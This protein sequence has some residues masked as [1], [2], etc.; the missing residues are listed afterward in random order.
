MSAPNNLGWLGIF[1]LGL[2][3]VALGAIVIQPFTTF[4]QAIIEDLGLMAMLPGFL[5]GL[6]YIIQLTRPRIGHG[7][8]TGGRRTPWI[9]G[10]ITTL[11][12]GGIT[13]AAGILAM[14]SVLWAGIAVTVFGY[15]LIGAGSAATGT[16]LLTFLAT[17]VDAKRR[18]LAAMVVW[19]MMIVGFAVT[20]G[21]VGSVLDPFSL[22]RLFVVVSIV[23]LIAFTL[24]ALALFRLEGPDIAPVE[25]PAPPGSEPD[26]AVD[27]APNGTQ[28]TSQQHGSSRFI[29]ALKEVWGDTKARRFTIFV[30]ASM[31]AYNAHE[32]IIEP[33]ARQ[34]FDLTAGEATQLG[35]MFLYTGVLLGMLLTG[36]AGR[37]APGRLGALWTWA[38]GGCVA[39]GIALGA[40]GIGSFINDMW[41]LRA[42]IFL[43]GVANGAFAVA[44]IGLMMRL[45]N[46]GTESREGVRIGLW[47][48][49]QA[50]AF[51]LGIFLGTAGVDIFR[52]IFDQATLGYNVVFTLAAGLFLV[53]AWLAAR[54][55]AV[56]QVAT[57]P[58]GN[59]R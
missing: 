44:A 36:F 30:F 47:G 9:L 12:I 49:A 57:K 21:I 50:I 45:A 40:L 54:V 59:S 13:T 46:E 53:S 37:F 20:G 3:Q 52:Y 51:G 19:L 4:N 29:E 28:P 14:E 31:L 8:D 26:G 15:F 39:S 7:L 58:A 56:D 33:F 2:V 32:T 22:E 6:Y 41:P 35:G 43:L 48:A 16:A 24:A 38:I 18:P 17:R 10:G 34:A 23:C 5:G 55:L 27:G 11:A 1:R 42:S 25:S